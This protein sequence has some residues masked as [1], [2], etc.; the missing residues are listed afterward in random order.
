MAGHDMLASAL[1]VAS[2]NRT[3]SVEEKQTRPELRGQPA[4]CDH[5]LKP[6][7][8]FR[9]GEKIKAFTICTLFKNKRLI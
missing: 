3:A 1:L 6:L 2:T 5:T 8:T 9:P 7:C 4:A